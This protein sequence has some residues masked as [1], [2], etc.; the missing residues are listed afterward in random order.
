MS[1]LKFFSIV[2]FLITL[3]PIAAIH[4]KVI[5]RAD[6]N[7][8]KSKFRSLIGYSYAVQGFSEANEFVLRTFN[9]KPDEV[10]Q[11]DEVRLTI[12]SFKEYGLGRY[13]L[14]VAST[15]GNEVR[16]NTDYLENFQ[17][18]DVYDEFMGILFHETT[19]LWQWDG[20]GTAPK[21]LINGIADFMRLSAGWPS[22][23]WTQRRGSG[24]RW[25]EGYAVTAYF[26]EY[27]SDLKFG[28][29]A[30]LNARMKHYYSDNFFRQLLG[31]SVHELWE[32]YKADYAKKDQFLAG[33]VKPTYKQAEE[34]VWLETIPKESASSEGYLQV[35]VKGV[36][37]VVQ[38]SPDQ[39]EADLDIERQMNKYPTE[40]NV[41]FPHQ[42]EKSSKSLKSVS[43][44]ENHGTHSIPV[45]FS[46][47]CTGFKDCLVTELN[48]MVEKILSS[49][50][51]SCNGPRKIGMGCWKNRQ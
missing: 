22:V 46:H 25:D 30:E 12:E 16:I 27:C 45:H 3:K 11:Y 31:K 4:Y 40:E 18:G 17:S 26:L 14:S 41:K 8:N 28:F 32:D 21:G 33:I 38:I 20:K 44:A 29:I 48:D 51:T 43:T 49:V 7:P 34:P 10:K 2:L 39:Y 19:H 42:P 15:V 23:G 35:D 50:P 1:S 37:G 24:S 36:Y 47:I 13:P 9:L 5:D 6:K